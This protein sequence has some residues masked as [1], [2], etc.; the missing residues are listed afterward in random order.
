M[1]KPHREER[2][3]VSALSGI[4][5]KTG[6][7]IAIE[8]LEVVE[9]SSEAKEFQEEARSK[10]LADK[11]DD[12]KCMPPHQ[13]RFCDVNAGHAGCVVLPVHQENGTSTKHLVHNKK[14]TCRLDQAHLIVACGI[15]Q[16]GHAKHNDTIKW[17][18]WEFDVCAQDFWEC[19]VVNRDT[20]ERDVLKQAFT[21]R[22][23]EDVVVHPSMQ[24]PNLPTIGYA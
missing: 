12:C 21:L 13:R 8:C 22:T 17:I 1:P 3:N 7:E 18:K 16:L 2:V 23:V 19:M 10:H 4:L 11:A 14:L 6:E 5:T 15:T 24:C 20:C 9:K